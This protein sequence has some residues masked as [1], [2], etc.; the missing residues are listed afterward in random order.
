MPRTGYIDKMTRKDFQLIAGCL[1]KLGEMEAHCFDNA[2]DR[3][4]IAL[5]FADALKET[6]AQFRSELF[7]DAATI[8]GDRAEYDHEETYE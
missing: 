5:V 8:K 2:K 3:V 6:N 7:V 4:R 1:Q